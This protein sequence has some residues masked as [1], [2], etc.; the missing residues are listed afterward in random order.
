M[1]SRIVGIDLG[2]TYSAVAV[3][4]ESGTPH[5][6]W[7]RDGAATMPSVVM[8]QD[9]GNGDEPLVGAQAKEMAATAPDDVVQHVKRHM[10]DPTWRFDSASGASYTAEEISALILK[11][12]K[13]DA[14]AALGEPVTDAVVTVPAYFDDARRTATRQ[15]GQIAGLNVVRVLNEPTAAALCYG[16]G[17]NAHA[18]VLVYDLGGG[19]FDATL[20]RI[21][22]GTF[23]VLGTDGDRNLG[24]FDF[25]NALALHIAARMEE[26]GAVNVLDDLD[27]AAALR[28]KA[29]QAKR[30]LSTAPGANV[31]VTHGGQRYRV[32]VRAEE[33][34]DLTR[35]LV[36]RTE[37][38]VEDVLDEGDVA[39]NEL[40]AVLL[41]GGSTRMP[42]VRGMLEAKWG[43]PIPATVNPDE[44]VA[45]G[46]A[47]QASIEEQ[48]GVDQA[49]L[50][51]P[52]PSALLRVSDVT[53]QALG[54]LVTKGMEDDTLVNVVIIGRNAKVPARASQGFRTRVDQSRVTVQVTE[55][56]D[57]DPDFVTRIGTAV[58]DLAAPFPQGTPVTLAYSYD[59]D[60]MIQIE[61]YDGRDGSF[62]G[63]FEIQR[64]ANMTPAAVAESQQKVAGLDISWG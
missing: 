63:R 18:T 58:I 20:V 12:L 35:S 1:V 9:F 11:R 30:T 25:D 4:D 49:L 23:N 8:L 28:E 10:G 7:N 6:L 60:Q 51:Q 3:T 14:E 47:V 62:A 46:A 50:P 59:N 21:E 5:I 24:G 26:Q 19:T 32:Q 45:L 44:A 53:S 22:G 52:H 34:L 38:I 36:R 40:D 54:A 42:A 13:A 27:T 41:V 15:A 31:L 37:E 16:F 57:T 48:A 61:V 56:D 43:R 64:D 33:F 39:W 17:A 29:E 2:T 55:G